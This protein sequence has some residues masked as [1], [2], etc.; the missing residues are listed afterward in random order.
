MPADAD[1]FKTLLA[2]RDIKRVLQNYCRAIDRGDIELLRTVYHADATENHGAYQGPACD[3][4]QHVADTVGSGGHES[5]SHTIS[6]IRIELA[7]DVA[8][9]ETYL[10]AH[11]TLIDPEH[12]DQVHET[13]GGR[14]LDRF[15][16][17][18]G[19]WRVASRRVAFDW[20]R[21]EPVTER[22]YFTRKPSQHYLMGSRS[23]DD[24]SVT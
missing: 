24:P 16:R 20:S 5:T 17:R 13:I 4:V 10:N 1:A 14:Y 21:T 3:F 23:R 6:N 15:E 7:G 22:T 18:D 11:H 19:V 8:D 12:G 2:E 9:V